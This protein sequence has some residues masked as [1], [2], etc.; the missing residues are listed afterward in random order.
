MEV[1]SPLETTKG[2]FFYPPHYLC[3]ASLNLTPQVRGKSEKDQQLASAGSL[4]ASFFI[5]KAT[6][7]LTVSIRIFS[8]LPVPLTTLNFSLRMS[9]RYVTLIFSF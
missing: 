4:I 5:L 8:D 3:A 2:P 6:D 7:N 9:T 1:S